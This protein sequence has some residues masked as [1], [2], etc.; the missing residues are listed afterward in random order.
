M[1]EGI[2]PTNDEITHFVC[3]G[4]GRGLNTMSKLEDIWVTCALTTELISSMNALQSGKSAEGPER[5]SASNSM[6]AFGK[7]TFSDSR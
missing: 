2:Q 1:F 7:E 4:Y 6:W 5:I 3:R